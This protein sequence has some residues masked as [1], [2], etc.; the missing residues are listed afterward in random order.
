MKAIVHDEYGEAEV[1]TLAEV[2]RPEPGR[3]EV[4]VEVRAAGVDPGVWHLMA[5]LP[6][7]VRTATGLRRP[8]DRVRGRDFAG[9]VVAVGPGVDAFEPGAEVFGTCG[10]AFAEYARVRVD[11]CTAKPPNVS[12]EQAAAL[13]VSGLTA[14]HAVRRTVRPGNSVLVIG[15][16]GGVGSFAVQLAK[17][18]GGEVTGVC[19]T[20]KLEL[21][22][23][24]GADHVVD[25]TRED[26][27]SGA[28]RYDV[29]LDTA[30]L[31]P[32]SQLRRALTPRGT[33]LIIGGEGGGRWLG[34]LERVLGAMLLSPFVSH[35][36]RGVI[37]QENRKDLEHLGQLV[38]DGTLTPV[39]DRTYPLAD[40]A[41]A[42]RYIVGGNARGKVVVTI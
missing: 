34:G 16:A 37:S 29:V 33:L 36:L 35:R 3:G 9:V 27:V 5:G 32:L 28:R 18:A 30:G 38:A 25:Y 42:I 31:R 15:A 23:S 6:Y 24:L 7:L 19:S 8:R 14:L 11:R 40:A 41:E 4:L 12:F 21:A 39:I 22:R 2:D 17:A 20:G 1:L 13:P 26:P 10:G